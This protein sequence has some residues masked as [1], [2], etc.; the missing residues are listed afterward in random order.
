LREDNVRKMWSDAELD[1]ALSDLHNDVD[2]DDSLA[3][4]RASLMAA[5]GT[6]EAPPRPRRAGTWRWIAVAAAV[7]TLV[8]GLAIVTSLRTSA[9]EPAQPAAMLADLDRPLEPGEFHYAQKLQWLPDNLEGNPAEVQ[10]KVELWIPA[11]PT[12]TWH[13]RTSW[14]GA[15]N[16]L[17]ADRQKV[18]PVNRAPFDEYGRGGLRPGPP[19]LAGTTEPTWNTPF[20]NWL[21]PDAAFIASLTPDRGKLVKRLGLDT[22]SLHDSGKA[23]TPTESLGMVRSVLE[24]GLVRKDVRFALRDA[25]G[26]ITGAFVV[27]GHTSDGR[28]ATVLG[29]KDSGQLMFLDPATAQLLS[30]SGRF[31]PPP[32]T[33][34]SSEVAA[35]T[36]K[37]PPASG[38]STGPPATTTTSPGSPV[39]PQ[40]PVNTETKYSFAITRTS[41]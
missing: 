12:G 37:N 26:E 24:T 9:P 14:T 1:A 10:Q 36:S 39:S 23:H 21:T 13:R 33:T 5:A 19:D 38:G 8:G 2:E 15:V 30:W 6:S 20:Q 16:G 35:S 18:V 32:T 29:A 41:G 22:I 7:V 28:P 34:R 17:P 4:A 27:P 40:L 31:P 3:F 11:D 25:F